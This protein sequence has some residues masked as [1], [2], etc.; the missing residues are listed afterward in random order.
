MG[1]KKSV[2]LRLAFSPFLQ[3]GTQL[4]AVSRDAKNTLRA[5]HLGGAS[6]KRGTAAGLARLETSNTARPARRA[7]PSDA[8]GANDE[9]DE[10]CSFEDVL[11]AA[12]AGIAAR[13]KAGASC[14][15]LVRVLG[16]SR[17]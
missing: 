14:K 8:S 16:F 2:A 13:K 1:T 9:V 11:A 3:D 10:G 12:N 7:G 17:G 15:G 4:V 5:F 6:S